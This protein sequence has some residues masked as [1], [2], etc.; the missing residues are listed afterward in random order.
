LQNGS[1]ELPIGNK[2]KFSS[3]ATGDDFDPWEDKWVDVYY[4]GYQISHVHIGNNTPD[5]IMNYTINFNDIIYA[6]L[7]NNNA[8][9]TIASNPDITNMYPD[10]PTYPDYSEQNY[11]SGQGTYNPWGAFYGYGYYYPKD[12]LDEEFNWSLVSDDKKE[13]YVE[14]G[15]GYDPYYTPDWLL[16]ERKKNFE[17]TYEFMN[18]GLPIGGNWATWGDKTYDSFAGFADK[19]FSWNPSV[20]YGIK[21]TGGF[22]KS[23]VDL[24]VGLPYVTGWAAGKAAATKDLGYLEWWVTQLGAGTAEFITTPTKSLDYAIQGDYNKAIDPKMWGEFTGMIFGPKIVKTVSRPIINAGKLANAKYI[25][26][27]AYIPENYLNIRFL[28][29]FTEPTGKN[30]AKVLEDAVVQQEKV[31]N[32]RT[33][34][35]HMT[36]SKG[37]MDAV[38]FTGAKVL[39]PKNLPKIRKKMNL[40][41]LYFSLNEPVKGINA[42]GHYVGLYSELKPMKREYTLLPPR[43][44][45]TYMLIVDAKFNKPALF[46]N[47]YRKISPYKIENGKI[48]LN[49]EVF[50]EHHDTYVVNAIGKFNPDSREVVGSDIGQAI[51]FEREQVLPVG[52]TIIYDPSFR[53]A[54]MIY[55]LRKAKTLPNFSNMFIKTVNHFNKMSDRLETYRSIRNKI[56]NKIPKP[57]YGIYNKIASYI[58]KIYVGK[59]PYTYVKITKN[60]PWYF[61]EWFTEREVDFA[62]TGDFDL[63]SGKRRKYVSSWRLNLA[64]YYNVFIEGRNYRGDFIGN[65]IE[66]IGKRVPYDIKMKI[67]A[68]LYKAWEIFNTKYK[69]VEIVPGEVKTGISEK[70]NTK[71]TKIE[72][73]KITKYEEY[74]DEVYKE[75]IWIGE[76][77]L[78]NMKYYENNFVNMNNYTS[79][80]L[81]ND[82]PIINTDYSNSDSDKNY[83]ETKST[84]YSLKC[85]DEYT[86]DYNEYSYDITKYTNEGY[87]KYITTYY[88][89]YTTKYSDKYRGGYSGKYTG[90]PTKYPPITPPPTPPTIPPDITLTPPVKPPLIRKKKR[91]KAD[92]D[93]LR[94][95]PKNYPQG[96]ATSKRDWYVKDLEKAFR[97]VEKQMKALEKSFNF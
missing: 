1:Y 42:Y 38:K 93:I 86:K 41:D 52:T 54:K 25:D 63:I 39:P 20:N 33:V 79:T 13:G 31:Y 44:T 76:S 69:K 87:S 85:N 43:N 47:P 80:T 58:G 61:P 49:T 78:K 18:D 66:K 22:T 60:P 77:I 8:M 62:T 84:N 45:N 70:I 65:V 57:A 37:F 27:G 48:V 75:K 7:S 94:V 6:I 21:F 72:S 29:H 81:V 50:R 51:H 19:Y 64:Y 35:V 90:Y 95:I 14:L 83:N 24:A 28:N 46:N 36:N 12:K 91:K 88:D 34:G 17:Y 23:V 4:A 97:D 92:E 2:A 89:K 96:A 71:I 82:T 16:N 59:N 11:W 30:P 26:K 68:G 3:G 10:F 53:K 73:D 9:N 15:T 5:A 55:D 56:D 32:G 74:L 40:H 67:D